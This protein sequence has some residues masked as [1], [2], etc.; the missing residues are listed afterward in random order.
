[1]K[2]AAVT[3]EYNP[4]HNGHLYHLNFIR[5]KLNADRIIVLMS[6]DFVQRGEP[7]II[8]KYRR[9][10]MAL[11]GGADLVIELPSYFALGSA[12]YFAQGAIS[13]LDKLGVVNILHFGSECGDIGILLKYAHFLSN[14]TPKY[15]ETLNAFLKQGLSFPTARSNALKKCFGLDGHILSGANNSLAIEYIKSIL[16]R[17]SS[18][19]PMTFKRKGAKYNSDKLISGNFSSAN[20]IRHLLSDIC[21]G[22]C[23]YGG[24]YSNNYMESINLLKEFV[25]AYTFK[26][27]SPISQEAFKSGGYVN[28]AKAG[29]SDGCRG[30]LLMFANDFSSILHYKLLNE[31]WAKC[32]N[33]AGHGTYYY[34]VSEA[35]ANTI[36]NKLPHFTSFSSFALSCKS[37]N[38]TYSHISRGF[39]HI[40]LGM[41]QENADLLK[42]SGYSQYARILGFTDNGKDIL[43]L[44]K[45]NSSIPI[46]TKPSKALKELDGISLISFKN[47]INV[48]N[49]YNSVRLHKMT[50]MSHP[51]KAYAMPNELTRKL[52]KL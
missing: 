43:K 5:E 27:L 13:L 41:T 24:S 3:A 34:D 14:E 1:M 28:P 4:F 47:D 12:E 20:A 44:I 19:T 17:N 30:N 15:K 50:H 2:I 25:P 8:D 38:L 36:F 22:V 9:C 16:Q 29:T 7:A 23:T 49:I 10:E 18:I 42:D 52:I 51:S 26:H 32:K 21:G 6:G 46:I 39:M 45:A 31:Q 40:I 48:T 11:R 33:I 37:K 35:F